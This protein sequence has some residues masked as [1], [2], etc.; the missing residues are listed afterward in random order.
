MSSL[1]PFD[2]SFIT[3]PLPNALSIWAM[4]ASSALCLSPSPCPTSRNTV[5]LTVGV[6]P[7]T[8]RAR[9]REPE[10]S[11][12]GCVYPFRSGNA[13][14]TFRGWRVRPTACSGRRGSGTTRPSVCIRHRR[15]NAPPRRCSSKGEPSS[16]T[17]PVRQHQYAVHVG[18]GGQA[19]GDGQHRATLHQVGEGSLHRGLG[20]GVQRRGRLVQDQDRRVLQE[21]AGDAD[22]LALAA[23]QLGAAVADH[24]VV[25][26]RQA[27]FDEP[28]AVGGA[29]GGE[30]L[31]DRSASGRPK[32]MFSITERWNRLTSWGTTAMRRAQLVL[33]EGL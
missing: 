29:G 2:P 25:A 19:V 1:E 12:T 4:A 16:M 14:G 17:S 31:L 23:G 8:I 11:A 21:G 26:F 33:G 32:R 13:S 20:L 7:D 5:W 10:I 9:R 22:A 6:L 24:G 3:E 28:L 27:R 15:A 18:Q 30:D